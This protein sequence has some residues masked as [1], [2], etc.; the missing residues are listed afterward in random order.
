MA[1]YALIG[2]DNIVVQVIV[3]RNEDEVVNG[4]SDWEEYYSQETGYLCK[5]T[6]FNT[7]GGVHAFGQTPF[8]KNYAAIG[9]TWREDLNSPEGAFVPMQP[10]PS[11][12]LNEDICLWESPIAPPEYP[13][14][15]DE[16]NQQW[17]QL[18]V[19]PAENS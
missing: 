16:E 6:S 8:R 4:V 10:Y 14:E 13:A 3:G 2:E 18:W 11:W 19:P 12:S 7:Y 1:H 17:V 15:W 9:Y 5:R